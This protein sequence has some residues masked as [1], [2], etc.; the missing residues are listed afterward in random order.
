MTSAAAAFDMA[1]KLWMGRR[2]SGERGQGRRSAKKL[3]QKK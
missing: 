1:E 2:E 3:V